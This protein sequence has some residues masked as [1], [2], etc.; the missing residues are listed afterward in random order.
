LR[1]AKLEANAEQNLMERPD[2]LEEHFV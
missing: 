1:S 2:G